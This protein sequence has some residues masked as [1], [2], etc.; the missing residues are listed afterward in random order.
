MSV[1]TGMLKRGS[2]TN[3]GE[4]LVMESNGR[5]EPKVQSLEGQ[6]SACCSPGTCSTRRSLTLPPMDLPTVVVHTTGCPQERINIPVHVGIW[7]RNDEAEEPSFISCIFILQSLMGLIHFP[8]YQYLKIYVLFLGIFLVL[9]SYY[10]K[11]PLQIHLWDSWSCREHF[12][13]LLKLLWCIVRPLGSQPLS[14][15]GLVVPRHLRFSGWGP[16]LSLQFMG[17]DGR[18]LI[19]KG[20]EVQGLSLRHEDNAYSCTL[21]DRGATKFIPDS[22]PSFIQERRVVTK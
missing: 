22:A 7:T 9:L 4:E 5:K 8:D 21:G 17:K 19:S 15:L 6:H 16:Q 12:M 2:W 14:L 1:I 13:T 11:I 10:M 20:L 18:D 3:A